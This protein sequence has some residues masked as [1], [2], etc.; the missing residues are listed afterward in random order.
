LRINDPVLRESIAEAMSDP[1][2]RR[3]ISA[4]LTKSKSAIEIASELGI[5]IRSVYR[6]LRTLKGLGIL[7]VQNQLILEKGGKETLYRSMVRAVIIRCEAENL[8]VDLLPNE[9]ILDRFLRFW[10]YMGR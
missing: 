4:T 5:P 2:L 6:H 3:I 8:E 1:Q 10:S 7:T 9:G